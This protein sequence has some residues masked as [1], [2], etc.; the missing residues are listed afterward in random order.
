MHGPTLAQVHWRCPGGKS[1]GAHVGT[2][3]VVFA[4]GHTYR[5]AH[6]RSASGLRYESG[7]I[8]Y[9]EHAGQ[10]SLHGAAGGPYENCRHG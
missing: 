3:A 6:A 2:E 5:L 7:G 4:A 9:W 10:A 8:E 1:F